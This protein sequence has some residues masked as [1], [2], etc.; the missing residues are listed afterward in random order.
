MRNIIHVL[1]AGDK[2]YDRFLLENRNKCLLEF[3]GKKL[4]DLTLSAFSSASLVKALVV[5]G[6]DN[7]KH[8]IPSALAH[9]PV[10]FL[11]QRGSL[12]ENVEAALD[13]VE[14]RWPDNHTIFVTNDAPLLTGTELDNFATIT[15][16]Q[17]ADVNIAI[18][19]IVSS[20]LSDPLIKQYIRSAVIVSDG[21]YLLGNQ[22]ALSKPSKELLPTIQRFFDMRKQSH[23]TTE[24]LTLLYSL[25]QS[26]TRKAI[27]YW[28]RLIVAKRLWMLAADSKLSNKI[29]ISLQ[30]VEL[31]LGRLLGDNACVRINEVPNALGC[32]DADTPLQLLELRK[33]LEDREQKVEVAH[34]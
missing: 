7:L 12:S 32:F 19:R 29:A 15:R 23:F 20:Q 2:N 8:F 5:V 1:L 26:N 33:T 14:E 34:A 25:R 16:E 18:S 3:S 30:K 27:Y 11:Q 17:N 28:I 9:R 22:I 24:I 21:I 13:F 31:G 6:P 10:F 4:L